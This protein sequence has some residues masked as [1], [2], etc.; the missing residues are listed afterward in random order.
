MA[1]VRERARGRGREERPSKERSQDL[2]LWK[3]TNHETAT[4]TI[5]ALDC[6]FVV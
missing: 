3:S 1:R 6:D 2:P 4:P 5:V